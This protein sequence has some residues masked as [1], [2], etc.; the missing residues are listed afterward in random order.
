MATRS[1][2]FGRQ[3]RRKATSRNDSSDDEG[4]DDLF[5][6]EEPVP[7]SNR[8]TKPNLPKKASPSP[9]KLAP[10]KRKFGSMKTRDKKGLMTFFARQPVSAHSKPSR[11][12]KLNLVE[13][14][15]NGRKSKQSK[16]QLRQPVSSSV[17]IP[18]TP[19]FGPS[20]EESA[21]DDDDAEGPNVINL[22]SQNQQPSQTPRKAR[23][24]IDSDGDDDDSDD[25]PIFSR[26]KMHRSGRQSATHI[27]LPTDDS[28]DSDDLSDSDQERASAGNATTSK[29]CC[30]LLARP[31]PRLLTAFLFFLGGCSNSH[32][33]TSS[34]VSTPPPR[35]SLRSRRLKQNTSEEKTRK[36]NR[37]IKSDSLEQQLQTSGF[38]QSD[39]SSDDDLDDHL[40]IGRQRPRKEDD[41]G[42]FIASDD[43]VEVTTS[44]A[45]A[46]KR[47][48]PPRQWTRASRSQVNK[49]AGKVKPTVKGRQPSILD[50]MAAAVSR[51]AS[52]T[53][54]EHTD[55]DIVHLN[56]TPNDGDCSGG[57]HSDD[58]NNSDTNCFR[59]RKSSK[60]IHGEESG[61]HGRGSSVVSGGSPN[62]SLLLWE[63]RLVKLGMHM[64]GELLLTRIQHMMNSHPKIAGGPNAI[65]S[66]SLRGLSI[67][68]RTNAALAAGDTRAALAV[69]HEDDRQRRLQM[70]PSFSTSKRPRRFDSTL[71]GDD[72]PTSDQYQQMVSP[73]NLRRHSSVTFTPVA[74]LHIYLHDR[75]P[76][77]L[78]PFWH[79]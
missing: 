18:K 53:E 11:T 61:E 57:S 48:Q 13:K 21:A 32:R 20:S 75:L 51:T 33:Q 23:K 8:V 46:G 43:R 3:G 28:S 78:F 56:S 45:A 40:R 66:S 5:Y 72:V 74:R 24:R 36:F 65:A 7:N 73:E 26:V 62:S 16:L 12:P 38:Q 44:S 68:Q 6:D 55:D 22:T 42:S 19:D 52:S 49:K 2:F 29:V 14:T 60:G 58:S 50:S 71:F 30:L 34:P 27:E 41:I 37:Y 47:S 31:T 9:A 10:S 59:R 17:K 1:R 54:L 25:D 76:M 77:N 70:S 63:Q 69:L 35:R 67:A 15:P 39:S 64:C 4:S 79:L